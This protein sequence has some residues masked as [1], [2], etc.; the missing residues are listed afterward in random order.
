MKITLENTDKI[1][2]LEVDGA[3]VPAR[4]WQ[5]ESESGV[6][7]HAFITRVAP[8]ILESNPDIDAL[9]EQFERELQRTAKPR[10]MIDSIPLHLIL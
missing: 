9:T 5:G 6:P 10:A 8:E 3:T 2:T 4:I 1:V 7:V